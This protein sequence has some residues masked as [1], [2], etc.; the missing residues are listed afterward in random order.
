MGDSNV[1][2]GDLADFA[3]Q[4]ANYILPLEQRL[5]ALANVFD[6]LVT[7]VM[8]RENFEQLQAEITAE[9]ERRAK[10]LKPKAKDAGT[11]SDAG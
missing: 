7:V 3:R 9:L 10:E 8:R 5:N 1:K 11:P 4:T 2:K 6:A